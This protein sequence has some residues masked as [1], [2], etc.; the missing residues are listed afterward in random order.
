MHW[1]RALYF[2]CLGRGLTKSNRFDYIVYIIQENYASPTSP[3]SPT[4][5]ARATSPLGPTGPAG[6]TGPSIPPAL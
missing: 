2:I 6:P 1:Q 3:M 4:S 5:P